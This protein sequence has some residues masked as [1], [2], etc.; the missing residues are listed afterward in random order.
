MSADVDEL[1]AE[2][3]GDLFARHSGPELWR[4][5]PEGGWSPELWRIVERAELPRLGVPLELGGSGGTA[6]Q[7]ALVWGIA[8]RHAA[9]VPLAETAL[10]GHLLAAADVPPPDGPLTFARAGPGA[11]AASVPYARH[12]GGLAV[13]DTGTAR[14]AFVPLE[15]CEVT[16]GVNLAGEPRDDVRIPADCD[17]HDADPAIAGTLELRAAL[18]RSAQLAGAAAAA[19]ELT[20]Q[21]VNGREQFGGPLGRL[22][23]VRERLALMA[24]EVAAARAAVAWAAALVATDGSLAVPAAKVRAGQAAGVVARLA[25]QLHGAIGMTREHTLH[26]FTRRLWAWRDEAGDERV[27]AIRLGEQV[28]AGGGLWPQLVRHGAHTVSPA[29]RFRA[30]ARP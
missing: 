8:A 20:A 24:E 9:P 25:H 29:S 14:V 19:L 17:W 1:L 28:A 16:P 4:S 23:T 18:A 15:R 21:H 7:E 3:A 11:V 30:R 26:H 12:A 10:A 5:V 2:S 27:W 22:P 6:E 13:L